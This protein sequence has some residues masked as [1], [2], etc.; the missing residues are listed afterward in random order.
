MIHSQNIIASTIS[1]K[2]K[3]YSTNGEHIHKPLFL[4]KKKKK[5]LP[6]KWKNYG[7][8]L[9]QGHSLPLVAQRAV[10]D[11]VQFCCF[12]LVYFLKIHIKLAKKRTEKMAENEGTVIFKT[13]MEI[14]LCF[15]TSDQCSHEGNV[16]S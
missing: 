3:F 16:T 9:S 7:C 11:Y 10:K 1:T 12:F 6:G 5:K 15:A 13:R 8:I 2:L 14:Y 4:S